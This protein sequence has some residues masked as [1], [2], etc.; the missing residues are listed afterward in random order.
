MIKFSL[1]TQSFYDLTLNYSDLPNDLIEITT[2]QHQ[3]L[4]N[5]LNSG[6]VVFSDLTASPPR[7]DQHH[8]WNGFSWVDER[9][10]EEVAAYN[11]SLLPVLS[12]R[13]LALYLFDHQLHDQ[14]MSA[15]DQNLRFKI[16]YET[17]KD[18][19][20][21]SPTVSAMTALLGWSDEQV[22]EMWK[23]ALKL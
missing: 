3:E 18:L 5:V 19:E 4:L 20:R 8:T 9:T 21:L 17:V 15:L 23:E 13:Q 12:K 10:A 22:D 11:R 1:K 14:V 7:P 6:C 16:E 2:E